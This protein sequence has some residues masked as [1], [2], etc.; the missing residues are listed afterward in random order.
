MLNRTW[1]SRLRRS[2]ENHHPV[3]SGPR[4]AIVASVLVAV[5]SVTV[6]RASNA[7]IKPHIASACASP[8][9]VSS[10]FATGKL[11]GSTGI[12]RPPSLVTSRPTE[13]VLAERA[14]VPTQRR[15][16][17]SA[18]RTPTGTFLGQRAIRRRPATRTFWT[19]PRSPDAEWRGTSRVRRPTWDE[20][21]SVVRGESGVRAHA[22][23]LA[24]VSA[25][26]RHIEFTLNRYEPVL[27]GHLPIPNV[28]SGT[29]SSREPWWRG[30]D[31][32]MPTATCVRMSSTCNEESPVDPRRRRRRRSR[33]CERAPPVL[34]G[35]RATRPTRRSPNIGWPR[36]DAPRR[37]R[38]L[39]SPWR[40]R[41]PA[42]ST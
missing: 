32:F 36:T 18:R 21:L 37:R 41:R 42:G 15:D 8:A 11:A 19:A 6:G 12:R 3:W 40:W 35:R 5:A 16:R 34:G 38:R 4:W 27:L 39:P 20:R 23:L 30:Q 29:A 9:A 26:E 17:P 24:I 31:G 7:P 2:D 33:R 22:L 14:L 25:A 13:V 28:S 10:T 1:P